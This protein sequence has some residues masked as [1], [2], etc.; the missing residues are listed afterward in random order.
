MQLI[1]CREWSITGNAEVNL[2]YLIL[3]AAN[4]L[5]AAGYRTQLEE[6]RRTGQLPAC[7]RILLVPDP[8]GRR[9]GS[10]GS[11]LVALARLL[12]E[13]PGPGTIAERLA[14]K[15]VFLIHA[16]GDCKRLPGYAP[17]GKLFTPLPCRTPN[18]RPAALFDLLLANLLKLPA[19]AAGQVLI[20]CGDVL[21]TFDA[22]EARLDRPGITGLTY[23]DKVKRARRH[24]VYVLD[25]KGRVVQ[26]LQKPDETELR[27]HGAISPVGRVLID[28]G[29][30]SLDPGTVEALLTAAGA[31]VS[32]R[33]VH[34]STDSLLGEIEAGAAGEMD[35]YE[36]IALAMANRVTAADYENRVLTLPRNAHPGRRERLRGL[37]RA[38]RGLDFHASVLSYCD[39]FHAGTS[40]ELLNG[41]V[42][43]SRTSSAYAFA[44]GSLSVLPAS[45]PSERGFVFNSVVESPV[46]CGPAVLVEG[47]H[48]CCPLELAGRNMVTG[49]PA[50]VQQALR[51]P[52]EVGLLMVPVGGGSDWAAVVYGIQDDGGTGGRDDF[53]N[54]LLRRQDIPPEAVWPEGERTFHAARLWCVGTAEDV[55]EQVRWMVGA[56]PSSAATAWRKRERFSLADLMRRV[57]HERLL[58][59]RAELYRQFT[60]H[61]LFD[62]IVRE[63]D[64]DVMAIAIQVGSLGEAAAVLVDLAEGVAG[65][66]DPSLRA[67]ALTAAALVLRQADRWTV[68]PEARER[69]EK[70][71]HTLSGGE[72]TAE[73][74]ERA[75]S[76]AVAEAVGVH[77]A[78][79]ETLGTAAIGLDQVVW[80]TA[81]ARLDFA[82]GW[83]DTPPICTDCGGAVVNAAV[84][85]NGQYPIQAVA[86]LNDQDT[87]TLTSIDLGR[88]EICERVEDLLD[89]TD[90]GRWSSLPRACL[91]LTGLASGQTSGDLRP[92]LRRL[93]GGLELTLFSALPKGSGLGTSSILGAA[94]LS[95]LARVVGEILPQDKLISRTSLLEQVMTTGGGWQDQVGGILPGVK[96]IR[97]RP[98][99]DQTPTVFWSAF[100]EGFARRMLLYYTG[101]TR[102]AKNILQNVVHRYLARDPMTLDTIT[103]LKAE[104]LEMR[105]HIDTRDFEAF[106]AGLGRYWELK[107]RLDPG[108]TTPA[109]EVLLQR[110]APLCLGGTLLGAGGG[111][112][113]LLATRSEEAAH[114]LRGELTA[115]PPARGARFFDFAIDHQG[116]SVSVL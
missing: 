72:A 58:G 4:D 114:R 19:P 7:A 94:I 12:E 17:Q 43:R 102:L 9:V 41:L 3:S 99:P 110:V 116:L 80:V 71:C 77:V 76:A 50:E 42:G 40:A 15:R 2:D 37:Y 96:L 22:E 111:G 54:D 5:Q 79:R 86:K 1:S 66:P 31:T 28:T 60:L 103:R 48:V 34:F 55:A 46:Q 13:Q 44:N 56:G 100:E 87:I 83:S 115:A 25:E 101:L 18:G 32:A 81:P 89:Y 113:L 36:E 35:L 23:P 10:G 47:S 24:G 11:T 70:A 75:A 14:G 84:K 8:G 98:G 30:L 64:L 57:N 109:I 93:G 39:F 74:L 108:A 49:L 16:G 107:K 20:A 105:Q 68:Q 33:G 27:C 85:L 61:R 45:W 69:L 88:R 26:F 65:C 59:H 52:E 82:G 21:L 38:L 51:L 6:R 95:L 63:L 53:L 91:W 29:L 62:R 112:F 67:R 106:G 92:I 97:T 104:A 90:P 73:A 78:V